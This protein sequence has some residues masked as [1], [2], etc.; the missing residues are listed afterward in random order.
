MALDP[1]QLI[2]PDA[3]RSRISYRTRVRSSRPLHLPPGPGAGEN[4]P[5]E[6]LPSAARAS[7]PRVHG[8]FWALKYFRN[9]RWGVR[10]V[11]PLLKRILPEPLY[12][13]CRNSGVALLLY[14]KFVKHEEHRP[15]GGGDAFPERH[16]CFYPETCPS[17][18]VSILNLTPKRDLQ[19]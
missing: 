6:C 8:F 4:S 12:T 16:K 3:C 2:S 13:M 11:G 10:V 1:E 14:V 7:T 19:S 17:I 15:Q 5:I 18:L 9:E